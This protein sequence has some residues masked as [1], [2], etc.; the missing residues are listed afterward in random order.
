MARASGFLDSS[1]MSFIDFI[2]GWSGLL[3]SCSSCCCPL[4]S[5]AFSL[6]LSAFSA[7]TLFPFDNSSEESTTASVFFFVSA[8]SFSPFSQSPL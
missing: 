1:I 6:L 3:L 2:F 5:T 4:P 8:T 7:F